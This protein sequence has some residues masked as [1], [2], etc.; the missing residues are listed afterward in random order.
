MPFRPE[1]IAQPAWQLL[2][3]F[4][5]TIAALLL[6]PLP[7][8]AS[9][10]LAL[11]VAAAT[12]TLSLEKALAGYGEPVV[13]LVVGA[14][15]VAAAVG[16]TGLG[17]RIALVL[18]D[19]LGRSTLGVGY[20]LCGAEL[21]LGPVVPSNT[22][23]GGG[24]ISPIA[25]SLARA[26]G[27]TPEENPERAG[28]YFILVGAHANLITA[29]MFLTGMAANPILAK[30]IHEVLD[31]EYGWLRWALGGIVPGLVG[32]ALL[33][34]LLHRLCRPTLGDASKARIEARRQLAELGRLSTHEKILAAVFVLLL[35]LW[36]SKPWHGMGSTLVTWI[37]L[38]VLL[39]T[40]TLT[41]DRIAREH[42]AWDALVWLGGLL[43]LAN[44][45]KEKGLIDRFRVLVEAKIPFEGAI[46]VTLLLAIVY[47]FSMYGFS[48]LTAHITAMAGA[49]LIVAAA[50]G[51]P[52]LVA[53][54]LFAAFSN[55]CGA[56]TNYSTGPVVIYSGLGYVPTG[57]WF[58]IGL[59]VSLFHLAIWIG[60][61]M[62]WW[63]A[64]GW[65]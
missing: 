57:R 37:G 24:T 49:F 54:A 30:T 51:A 6:R 40:G 9:V 27:S 18:V 3:I 34:L 29:A 38:S 52:P 12:E 55:L 39:V 25:D 47:F 33:P 45:L 50:A 60:L 11:V 62:A 2:A 1:S 4:T 15:L 61:G 8:G 5:S 17:R 42:R 19:R 44:G 22:A 43:T 26:L 32:L 64:L 7:M 63:K 13:W 35:V 59:V 65:W 36:S 53:A 58:G 56:T 21:L 16:R 46:A 23:R 48:M 14:F 41:W 28:A 20:A 31:I 10:V